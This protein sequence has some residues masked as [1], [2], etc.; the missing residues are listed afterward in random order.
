MCHIGPFVVSIKVPSLIK[1]AYMGWIIP[2]RS[3][4]VAEQFFSEKNWSGVFLILFVY[5]VNDKTLAG[6]ILDKMLAAFDL[7]NG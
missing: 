2:F 1:Y 5:E 7:S 6:Q 3:P 4:R